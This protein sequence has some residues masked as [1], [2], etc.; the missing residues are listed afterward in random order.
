[1]N[2]VEADA[3]KYLDFAL[4]GEKVTSYGDP[5]CIEKIQEYNNMITIY[6]RQTKNLGLCLAF[7]KDT[8]LD[9]IKN[10]IKE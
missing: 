9:A 7:D 6:C 3:K 5:L 10:Y 2:K 8:F 4:M 1:M